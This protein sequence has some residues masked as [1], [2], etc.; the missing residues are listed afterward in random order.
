[1]DTLRKKL[2]CKM[3]AAPSHTW[4]GGDDHSKMKKAERDQNT[5]PPFP[6]KKPT[7]QR[8][9][10]EQWRA[11]FKQFLLQN[12]SFGRVFDGI[13]RAGC[14]EKEVLEFLQVMSEE[15]PSALWAKDLR[16]I[17]R[18]ADRIAHEAE[19]LVHRIEQ[20]NK[21]L[22]IG[23]DLEDSFYVFDAR[24]QKI[25]VPAADFDY[26][27]R[28]LGYYSQRLKDLVADSPNLSWLDARGPELALLGV[29]IREITG[30]APYLVISNLLHAVNEFLSRNIYQSGD[31]IRKILER[32]KRRHPHAY[33]TIEESIV[34]YV[35]R[36]KDRL[37]AEPDFWESLYERLYDSKTDDIL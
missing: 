30:T 36:R 22:F 7:Q 2:S 37:P 6:F 16:H 5:T 9:S 29:Y 1:M 28:L 10:D 25:V 19:A 12:P 34:A 18:E 26:L 31:A 11:G 35:Q 27:P 21:H 24:N 32:Y 13:I 17:V 14:E 4:T 3:S 33:E 8:L 20:M 23:V 15:S